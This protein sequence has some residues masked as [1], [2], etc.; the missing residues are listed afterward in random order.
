M[1]KLCFKR[2][3]QKG[4]VILE[5]VSSVQFEI[6]DLNVYNCFAFIDNVLSFDR[7]QIF[8]L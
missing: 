6:F 4:F 2:E 3:R 5:P 7:K 8:K 1:H